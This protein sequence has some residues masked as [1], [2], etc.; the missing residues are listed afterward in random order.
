MADVLSSIAQSL[1]GTLRPLASALD[2]ADDT[3]DEFALQLGYELPSVPPSLAALKDSGERLTASLDALNDAAVALSEDPAGDETAVMTAAALLLL[4]VGL[5]FD[6]IERLRTTLGGELPAPFVA[7]TNI[8]QDFPARLYEFLFYTALESQAPLPAH[9][10]ALFGIIEAVPHAADPAKFQPE[11]VLR[12]LRIERIPQLLQDPAGLFRDVYGWGTPSLDAERL[13]LALRDL[14]FDLLHPAHIEYPSPVTLAALGVEAA[15]PSDEGPEPELIVPVLET[16]QGTVSIVLFPIPTTSPTELQGLAATV[17]ADTALAETIKLSTTLRLD[18][19]A[20]VDLTAGV[21]AVIRPDAPVSILNQVSDGGL[22]AVLK[23]AGAK[24]RLAWTSV[25]ESESR[26]LLDIP[27]GSFIDARELYFQLE[28]S[29]TAAALSDFG[30]EG[31]VVGARLVLSTADSDSFLAAILPADGIIAPFEFGVGW[32]TARLIYFRGSAGFET[33]IPVHA[34]LGPLFLDSLHIALSLAA[35]G[36]DLEASITGGAAIGPIAVSVERIGARAELAFTR[37]NLGAADLKIAF[38]PPTGIGASVDAG[39]IT[40][41]GFLSIDH[42][43]GRYAGILQLRAFEIGI[44]AIALI[45]TRL[46]GGQEGYSFLIIIAVTLPP[47][48]LGYGFTLNGV[49]GLAGIHRTMVIDAIQ[50]GIR[51]HSIDHIL[52]PDDPIQNAAQIISDLRTIFPPAMNRFVFGPMAIIGWGT[53]TLVT[54]ELGILIE[55]PAPVRLVLLGQITVKA[56]VPDV[57][58]VEL[59]IDILGILDFE[60]RRL[61]IDAVLH[62]SRVAA[63]SLS[64]DMAFRLSWGASPNF[65]MAVGGLNPRFQPPPGFPELRRITV[66]LGFEENPRISVQGYFAI[67]SNT[68]Q[69]GALSEVYAEAG[70]FNVYGWLAFD[71]LLQRIPLWFAIDF[72]TGV[73]LR[74]GKRTLASVRLKGSLTGP[75][76]YHIKGEACLSLLFFDICVPFDKTFGSEAPAER[77]LINAWDQLQAAIL[78]A[79]SWS[80]AL[81]AH[82]IEAITA[83]SSGDAP[84]LLMDPGGGVQLRERVLPLN[85]KLDKLGEAVL[86]GPNRYDIT[87]VRVGTEVIQAYA[88]TKDQ[89][90][91]AQFEEL[92]DAEKLSVPSFEPMDAGIEVGRNEVAAGAGLTATLTYETRIVDFPYDGRVGPRYDLPRGHLLAMLG[93]GAAAQAP[94]KSKGAARFAPELGRVLGTTF[95]DETYVIASTIDLR[96]R[97]DLAPPS[98]KGDVHAALKAHLAA[99]PEDREHLQVMALHEAA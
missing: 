79:E 25:E 99:H 31:G 45:D 55:L 94:I 54:V 68:I 28:A 88:L 46:P 75:S 85:R 34:Q 81:P 35:E 3:M 96:S 38:K 14:S 89:F 86:T 12:R 9:I 7:A 66:S 40:G 26:R 29:A 43:N 24:L 52:F 15:V 76:P 87:E 2:A 90:A 4:D 17:I 20:S 18:I 11:F 41:G 58:V 73:A 32:S 13:F 84:P 74:R 61:S 37:G 33:T 30:V 49:G 59:H 53:P 95:E 93:W 77:P 10:L 27:G 70:G 98:S 23:G 78:N 39:P 22:A 5:T 48:Q 69:F 82:A 64:G 6:G 83:R 80:A 72:S 65:A 36:L 21:L 91:R 44:T 67:T 42:E 56:P 50:A 16:D 57:P 51:N 8:A 97:T 47:I 60:G 92:T 19:T 1:A 71:A 63:F 62:D